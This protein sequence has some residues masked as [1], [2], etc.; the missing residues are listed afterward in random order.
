MDVHNRVLFRNAVSRRKPFL[1]TDECRPSRR[2]V[3][4]LR[5]GTH[6]FQSADQLTSL[7][8]HCGAEQIQRSLRLVSKKDAAHKWVFPARIRPRTFGWRSSGAA[9]QRIKE[10]ISEIQIV[11][12]HDPTLGA[13]GAVRLIERLSPAL[14]HVDS[15]SGALG[16]AVNRAIEALVPLIASAPAPRKLR[17]KWL[18]RLYEAH[19]ADEMPYIEILAD[20]WGDVCGCAEL[21]NAWADRLIGITTMALS[22]DKSLRGHFHGTTAC[23]S[24]LL[25]SGRYTEIHALLAATD[26]WHYKRYSVEGLAQEGR[27]EEAIRLAEA[28]RG[29][30]TSNTSVD[31]L[32][33]RILRSVGRID[34]AYSR[35]GLTAHRAGTYLATFREVARAYP[36]IPLERI[37]KDLLDL[38]PGD[39]G[40]WF[41][42]A[43]SLGLLDMALKLVQDSPCDP[44]TLARAARDFVESEPTFARGAGLAALQWL[45]RGQGYEVTSADVWGAYA[46]TLRAAN[47]LGTNVDTKEAIRKLVN[48]EAAGGF[49]RQVLGREL[50][51][52]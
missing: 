3:D 39:E 13:E 44:K 30:W 28:C 1:Q 50:E 45:V 17:E 12:R 29:P 15:S 5:V 41:A 21:A 34:E 25:R 16:T 20:H 49:V 52:P 38:S 40:K 32:C 27:L 46:N 24:A 6:S 11:A 43:K 14:E 19:A 47:R 8:Y 26:F 35:Y 2:F 33:E 42:T 18:E 31:R 48:T 36:E 37:F 9:I 10:A 22:P 23:L 7:G 51:L 4:D